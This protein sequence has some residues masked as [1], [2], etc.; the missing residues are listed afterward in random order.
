MRK[1]VKSRFSEEA[2]FLGKVLDAISS[3][4]LQPLLDVIVTAE[5]ETGPQDD[6]FPENFASPVVIL[7][8]ENLSTT[9]NIENLILSF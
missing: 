6:P 8:T 2:P 7:E 3:E 9:V 5:G 4:N 1:E